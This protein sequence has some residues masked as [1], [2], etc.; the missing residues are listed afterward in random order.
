M[1]NPRSDLVARLEPYE[2]SRLAPLTETGLDSQRVRGYVRPQI[3]E[4]LATVDTVDFA[5]RFRGFC[6]VDGA[7]EDDYRRRLL[8]VETAPALTIMVGIRFLGGDTSRPFIEIERRSRPLT[9]P[10]DLRSV[11]ERLRS[12]LEVFGAPRL[13]LFLTPREEKLLA[14]LDSEPDLR[15]VVGHVAH[16]RSRP[17]PPSPASIIALR[18][19]SDLAF[20]PRYESA[21]AE[22]SRGFT[23][24][25]RASVRLESRETLAKCRDEGAL[26]EI[27]I[28]GEWAGIIAATRKNGLGLPGFEVAEEILTARFR[29]RGLAKAVQRQFITQLPAKDDDFLCGT[30]L[31]ENRPSLRTALGVGRTDLGGFHFIDLR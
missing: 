27:L 17:L 10:D 16:L 13:R 1:L 14:R 24:L 19:P 12:E 5:R 18:A 15:W 23:P 30:I 6:P 25:M 8:E 21:H 29:G 7:S 4:D 9:G 2:C 26:F 20:Y 11:R 22:A 31:A 3:E 28:D